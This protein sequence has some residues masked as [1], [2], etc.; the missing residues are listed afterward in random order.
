MPAPPRS[1][2]A[3]YRQ[4]RGWSRVQLALRAEVTE[5]TIQRAERLTPPRLHMRTLDAI[6]KAL[7]VPVAEL[8]GPPAGEDPDSDDAT[9]APLGT[10]DVLFVADLALI[11]RTS[12]RRIKKILAT[13]PWPLPER[14]PAIDKRDRWA[15]V[16]VLKWLELVDPERT[17]RAAAAQA[18]VAVR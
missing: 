1:P 15:R 17:R 12:E 16:V 7:D 9:T 10:G 3:H 2:I 11:L 4:Q 5:S 14:L 6:A 8:L 18:L 13:E